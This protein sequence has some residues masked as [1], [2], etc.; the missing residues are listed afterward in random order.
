VLLLQLKAK[1]RPEAGSFPET[2]CL[3]STR[4]HCLIL[5]FSSCLCYVGS[6]DLEHPIAATSSD[7]NQCSMVADDGT[8]CRE[9]FGAGV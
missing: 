6:L 5:T 1:Q 8:T 9:V 2:E 4:W 3:H 7:F